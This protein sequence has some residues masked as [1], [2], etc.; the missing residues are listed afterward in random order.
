MFPLAVMHNHQ[1]RK[2]TIILKNTIS[3]RQK[4]ILQLCFRQ[5]K[6][7][8]KLGIIYFFIKITFFLPVEIRGNL[9][10]KKY[11]YSGWAQIGVLF[12]LLVECIIDIRQS[13]FFKKSSCQG[14]IIP[15]S[16]QVIFQLLEPLFLRFCEIPTSDTFFSSSGSGV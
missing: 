16:R 2:N 11:R 7:S 9:I 8:L 6:L 5:W 3:A 14:K 15:A 12:F 4:R 1:Q 13:P 10:F